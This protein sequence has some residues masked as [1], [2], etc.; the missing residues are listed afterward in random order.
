[1][2]FWAKNPKHCLYYLIVKKTEWMLRNNDIAYAM[3]FISKEFLNYSRITTH[4]E[5]KLEY[6]QFVKSYIPRDIGDAL[7]K[8]GGLVDEKYFISDENRDIFLK[9]LDK[10]KFANLFASKNT[11]NE[12]VRNIIYRMYVVL[13][14]YIF[15]EGNKV[16]QF[17]DILKDL[18]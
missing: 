17:N 2:G 7:R 8:R 4:S 15:V 11:S 16:K 10:P 18:I 6:K 5:N 1:M 3:P 12:S 14:N 13:F 9:I